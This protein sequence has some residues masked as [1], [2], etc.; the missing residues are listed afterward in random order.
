MTHGNDKDVRN[1]G[2]T[3]STSKQNISHKNA[4]YVNETEAT[5]GELWR[6]SHSGKSIVNTRTGEEMSLDAAMRVTNRET[7]TSTEIR[8]ENIFRKY[9]KEIQ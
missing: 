5:L 6:E 4:S 1:A 7:A 2:D 9:S 3:H 8:V